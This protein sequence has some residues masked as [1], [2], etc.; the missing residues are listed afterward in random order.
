MRRKRLKAE[1]GA[2]PA[3]K[4]KS[5]RPWERRRS[6]VEERRRLVTARL[7]FASSRSDHRLGPVG[8]IGLTARYAQT[9]L[10]LPYASE[11]RR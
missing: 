5:R 3:C 11:R 10:V 2:D 8:S 4:E 6:R 9:H 7:P 1:V